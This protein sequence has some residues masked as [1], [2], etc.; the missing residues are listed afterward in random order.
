MTKYKANEQELYNISTSSIATVEQDVPEYQ[1]ITLATIKDDDYQTLDFATRANEHTTKY[2]LSA[3]CKVVLVAMFIVVVL[4]AVGVTVVFLKAN[5]EAPS[6]DWEPWTGWSQCTKSCGGGNKTR[7]RVCVNTCDEQYRNETTHCNTNCCPLAE[8]N[9]WGPWSLCN[10]TCGHLSIK[11]R[12]RTCGSFC[13]GICT[14]EDNEVISCLKEPV[15]PSEVWSAWDSWSSCSVTCGGGIKTRERTCSSCPDVTVEDS[16]VD[17]NTHCC[18]SAGWNDWG[19]WSACSVSCPG[20]GVQQRQRTCDS[21]CGGECSESSTDVQIC[22]GPSVCP[23]WNDWESWSACSVSCPGDGV[24]QRQ[25]TCDSVCGGECSG[26]STYVQICSGPSIGTTGDHG[27]NAVYLVLVM[28]FSNDNVPVIVYVVVNVQD[29]SLKHGHAQDQFHVQV[30]S[31]G[32]HG[33]LVQELVEPVPRL[34]PVYVLNAQKNRQSQHI[35]M[36]VNVVYLEMK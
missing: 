28:E 10:S 12:R 36:F 24:Q 15:C 29:L 4:A 19:S 30:G 8:W 21:V 9:H 11:H 20:D 2:K 17:C 27:R 6:D 14:G 34:E 31:H 16:P 13:D 5:G 35:V 3:C 33:H 1:T 25:R 23:D 32:A 26:S 22:S 7:S 18:P